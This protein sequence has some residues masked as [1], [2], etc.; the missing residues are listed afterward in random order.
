MNI[1]T[2]K[3]SKEASEIEVI[4]LFEHIHYLSS[5]REKIN[6]ISTLL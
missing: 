6:R 5:C 3:K 2:L 1:K 4:I